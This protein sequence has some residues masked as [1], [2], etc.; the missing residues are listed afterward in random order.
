M[1]IQPRLLHPGRYSP[2]QALRTSLLVDNVQSIPY[3][4][5]T[6]APAGRGE[7]TIMRF[8]ADL[9]VS[10]L[11]PCTHDSPLGL[12]IT[13]G[14]EIANYVE[15]YARI[16]AHAELGE[17]MAYVTLGETPPSFELAGPRSKIFFAPE[18][19]RAAIVTCGGLC[20]GLNNVIRGLTLQLWNRYGVRQVLGVRYGYMGLNPECHLPLVPLTPEAVAEIH[21]HGGTFLG[22]SRGPQDI[23]VMVD[24]LVRE[25]IDILYALGG[26]GT[27]SGAQAIFEEIRRRGARIAVVGVPKTI[28]NDV[29]YISQTFGFDTAVDEAARAIRAAHVEAAGAPCGVGVVKLMGRYSG[30]IAASAALASRE[31]SLVLIPEQRFDLAGDHGVLAYVE[32]VV[33]DRTQAVIV[34]AEGAGQHLVEG[35]A[36]KDAS[37]NVKLK[38]IGLYLSDALKTHF[39]A[40][41]LDLNLKYIDPSYL[42]RAAPAN[43][44]DAIYCG[45]LAEHAAH[46]GMAGKTGCVVG[47]WS[48]R[49]TL[50]PLAAATSARKVVDLESELWRSTLESTGQP[51]MLHA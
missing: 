41:N 19:T 29:P 39:K 27:L 15:P 44:K 12:N 28:D 46:A 13:E 37:G 23:G 17:V 4:A 2:S 35:D 6:P 30:Y 14:D 9:T 36:A 32:R 34:V 49:F 48:D 42:I 31:V 8:D 50:V 33:R 43:S 26:D 24:T 11:G 5:S 51:P 10:T 22:S 21:E 40:R 25:Q 47:R 20:P 38:D 18:R 7:S 3:D 45:S 16:L 1:C